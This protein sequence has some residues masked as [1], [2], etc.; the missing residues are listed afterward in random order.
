MTARIGIITFPG[1]LDDVDA[2]R[3]ARRVGAEPV[4]LW[5]A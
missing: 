3:A 5:H 2:A 1:T 4:N